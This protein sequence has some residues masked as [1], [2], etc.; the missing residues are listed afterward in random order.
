MRNGLLQLVEFK[1]KFELLN[2]NA[3]MQLIFFE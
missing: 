2:Q 1:D 3:V